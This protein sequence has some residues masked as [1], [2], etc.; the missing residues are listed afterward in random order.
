MIALLLAAMLLTAPTPGA[1]VKLSSVDIVERQFTAQGQK[2]P[3][4]GVFSTKYSYRG[5]PVDAATFWYSISVGTVL[6]IKV[7]RYSAF[8]VLVVS[9]IN[10]P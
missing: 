5:H 1:R 10:V 8:N 9:A 6:D 3:F 4:V 7:R 2:T